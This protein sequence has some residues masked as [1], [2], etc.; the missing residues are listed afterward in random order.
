M[1]T[2]QLVRVTA[3]FFCA[4]AVYSLDGR[5]LRCAPLLRSFIRGGSLSDLRALCAKRRWRLEVL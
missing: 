1:T 4:G 5:I 3:P 2:D